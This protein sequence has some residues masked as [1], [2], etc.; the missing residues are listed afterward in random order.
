M[1]FAM[2]FERLERNTTKNVLWMYILSL[3][4]EKKMYAYEMNTE[5][6]KRYGFRPG[7]AVAIRGRFK[8]S[9]SEAPGV[10]KET[11]WI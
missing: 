6:E 8:E 9:R 4:K 11:A 10:E 5:V 2:A 3:L 1:W 7:G